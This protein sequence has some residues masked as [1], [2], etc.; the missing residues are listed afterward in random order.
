MKIF[1]SIIIG[2]MF[3]SCNDSNVNS[4]PDPE[5]CEVPMINSSYGHISTYSYPIVLTKNNRFLFTVYQNLD[6]ASIC[7]VYDT[8]N[9]NIHSI[10]WSNILNIN[11]DKQKL[12]KVF[13]SPYEENVVLFE[14]GYHS[15]SFS[16]VVV[17]GVNAFRYVKYSA[18]SKQIQDI[19]PTQYFETGV[20]R[21]LGIRLM[22]WLSKSSS[23]NDFFDCGNS[24]VLHVQTGNIVEPHSGETYFSISSS[25]NYKTS[26]VPGDTMLRI[27][28]VRLD[29]FSSSTKFSPDE[30]YLVLMTTR[31]DT[32]LINWR[33]FWELYVYDINNTVTEKKPFIHSK[34]D[35]PTKL[36]AFQA[37][38]NFVIT[39]NNTIIISFSRYTIQDKSNLYEI[40][41]NGKIL[42]Q[43]TNE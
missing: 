8:E 19:T 20:P 33:H 41:F 39:P 22:T 7:R 43:L 32:G 2:L 5:P 35:F 40:D 38:S 28:D 10:E 4:T 21:S 37:S 16:S 23:N 31:Q 12:F 36:C 42:R 30:R 11:I 17:G 34:I 26:R 13:T 27:N 29:R 6:T 24:G 18:N 1:F 25:G 9:K 14:I 15:N 3:I